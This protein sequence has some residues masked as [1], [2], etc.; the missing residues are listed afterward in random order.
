MLTGSFI[1]IYRQAVWDPNHQRYYFVEVSTGR[2][3]WEMPTM[4]S[5]A[6][7]SAP[8]GEASSYAGGSQMGYPSQ[9]Q[10]YAPHQNYAPQQQQQAA[11]G[12]DERGLGSMLSGVMG[13][14]GHHG[15]GK[16]RSWVTVVQ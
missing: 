10:G 15:S 9:P 6:G 1:Y 11:G 16:N 4:P 2:T 12:A 5:A 3:Q 8:A 14:G 7:G 13:G